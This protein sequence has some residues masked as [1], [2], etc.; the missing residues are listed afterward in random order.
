MRVISCACERVAPL[1]YLIIK[2]AG[3]NALLFLLVHYHQPAR[4]LL[5]YSLD[6]FFETCWNSHT[7]HSYSYKT[8]CS[9]KNVRTVLHDVG[10]FYVFSLACSAQIPR[11]LGGFITQGGSARFERRCIF[12]PWPTKMYSSEDG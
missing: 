2:N 6:Q 3:I 4:V 12:C 11:L 8:V 1:C 5:E 7:V 10:F 9:C